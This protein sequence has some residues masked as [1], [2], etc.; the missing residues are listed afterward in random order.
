MGVKRPGANIERAYIT[1]DSMIEVTFTA[2]YT[3]T[4]VRVASGSDFLVKVVDLVS[5][6]ES[7][8]ASSSTKAVCILGPKLSA[9]ELENWET[10]SMISIAR[11]IGDLVTA[12]DEVWALAG[13]DVTVSVTLSLILALMSFGLDAVVD[14][15]KSIDTKN[16]NDFIFAFDFQMNRGARH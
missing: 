16:I 2:P 8:I 11:I 13:E 3:A 7:L 12:F 9:S 15:I 4:E 5:A 1:T 14:P 10:N 6:G